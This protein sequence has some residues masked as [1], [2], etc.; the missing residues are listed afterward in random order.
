MAEPLRVLVS[1]VQMQNELDVYRADLEARG[2][3][4]VVPEI[5]AQQLTE[6]DLLAIMPEID[7]VIAG[8]DHFTGKVLEASTRLKVL[9]KWGIGTDAIDKE[10]AARLGI[11]V[12][13]TPG[14]FGDEVADVTIC[15]LLML[16]R[17]LHVVDR[18]VR[19]G[20]WLK[21]EGE[22][23][24]G[25]TLGVVG[26]G[27]IGLA[28]CVRGKALNMDVVGFDPFPE[29]QER[30]RSLGVDV[31]EADDLF[32]RSDYVALNCPLTEDTYHLV[33]ER[34]LAL[35]KPGSKVIN[36]A[37]GTVV[38]EPALIAALQSGHLAAAA[39]DVFEVE[40]LPADSP[41]RTMPQV[42]LGAHNGSNTR[43]AVARTSERAVQNLLDHLFPS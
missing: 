8:D 12:T 17:G 13:N 23:P 20:T 16:A 28:T 31:L 32:S 5:T 33:N 14:M 38:D 43:E 40:P 22:S 26:L 41:L 7:G 11:P 27:S 24:S 1:C 35:M 29:A 6:P 30:A 25:K 36:T 42:V 39:L 9:S 10:A 18:A 21:Y 4:L 2:I 34:T 19:E 3:E 15:F 37:R